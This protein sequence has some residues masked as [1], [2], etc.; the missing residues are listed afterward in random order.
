MRADRRGLYYCLGLDLLS[1]L[2]GARVYVAIAGHL[3]R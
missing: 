2:F 1:T 3:R